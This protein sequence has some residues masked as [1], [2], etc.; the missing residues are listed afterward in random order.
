MNVAAGACDESFFMI[1]NAGVLL[2]FIGNRVYF[3]TVLNK[4]LEQKSFL[5]RQD[6]KTQ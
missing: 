5:L 1:R 2:A 3:C 4:R 6:I